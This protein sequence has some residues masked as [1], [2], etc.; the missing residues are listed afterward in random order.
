MTCR[1]IDTILDPLSLIPAIESE[2]SL[3]FMPRLATGKG[4]IASLPTVG[5]QDPCHPVFQGMIP[6]LNIANGR[7]TRRDPP[8][9][10]IVL[11]D[12]QL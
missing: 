12:L 2:V 4:L 8:P 6:M 11:P 7:H 10:N 9:P 5:M 3:Y 1:T